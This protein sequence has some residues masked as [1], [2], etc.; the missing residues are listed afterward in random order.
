MLNERCPREE[1]RVWLRTT[2]ADRPAPAQPHPLRKSAHPTFTPT[3]GPRASAHGEMCGDNRAKLV[4]QDETKTRREHR[5]Q[6]TPV[7]SDT[8]HS[9]TRI[10]HGVTSS[11]SK[12]VY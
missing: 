4:E 10:S 1:P 9:S 7:N 11:P 3:Q 2:P 6:G 8:L 5:K 12:Q